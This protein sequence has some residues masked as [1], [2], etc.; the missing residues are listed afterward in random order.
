MRGKEDGIGP[1]SFFVPPSVSLYNE[2]KRLR[3]DYMERDALEERDWLYSLSLIEGVGRG[4][5]FLLYE[6]LGCY[7]DHRQYLTTM[8][9]CTR[10]PRTTRQAILSRMNLPQI[11]Q[12]KK[13]RIAS[14]LDFTCFLDED[15]PESLRH[16]PDPPAILFYRGDFSLLQYHSIAI[17]GSRR[18]SSYGESA[19]Q[20]FSNGL[21]KSGMV[22]VSGMALGIDALA[23]RF[24][25]EAG[26]PTI[27]VMG[28]GIDQIY[29]KQNTYLYRKILA[30]GLILSE[31]PANTKL[32]PGLFPDRNRIISG[33]SLGVLVVEAAERSGS[34]ITADH[35]L[36]QGKEVFAVPGPIFSSTS[37]G[38]HSLIKQGAKMVTN[39]REVLEEFTWLLPT[40]QT[41]DDKIS[42]D[43]DE[44]HLL[45]MINIEPIHWDQLYEGINSGNRGNIDSLLL[46]LLTK[47]WIE[48]LPGGYY[49]RRAD[50]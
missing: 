45:S 10:I 33:I 21:S 6:M 44:R 22:V 15:F 43:S 1:S 42:L 9:S 37:G 24:A 41:D 48:W 14:Q 26:A 34:L 16:I 19:C 40:K 36:Q 35:A 38:P 4:I 47:K 30:S 32:H 18:T 31:Y 12:D 13:Q 25:L 27:A 23:H 2:G 29:P 8:Q 3:W 28:C 39:Y 17:V 5:L 20:Y 50:K 46:R 11:L 49:R 7:S